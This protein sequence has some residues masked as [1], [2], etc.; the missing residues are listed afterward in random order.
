M[1]STNSAPARFTA[2]LSAELRKA[3]SFPAIPRTLLL[4]ALVVLAATAFGMDQLARFR[5]QGRGGELA[6]MS[7]TDWSLT[8]L[9]YG[10]AIPILLG[11]W[12]FGQDLPAGPR[13]T[14]FLATAGR[15]RLAVAKLLTVASAALAAGVLCSLAAIMPLLASGGGPVQLL[16]Y[17]WLIGYW[18][19]V[20]LV[21]AALVAATRSLLLG[22]V[23]VLVWTIGASD[24]LAARFP[25]LGGALDQVFK[26]AYMQA[27]AAPPASCLIAAALQVAAAVAV[28]IAVHRRRDVR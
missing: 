19:S 20:A 10:Q 1:A 14:A 18:V 28:G 8:L 25:F 26:S 17:G 21:A 6:G 22:V 13:R 5:V 2:T 27:G 7:G 4:G 9:H 16:P 15:V 11:A 3:R 23:P 24:L 12:V